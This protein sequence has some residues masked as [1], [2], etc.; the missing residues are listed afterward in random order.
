MRRVRSAG[1]ASAILAASLAAGGPCWAQ[2]TTPGTEDA[3]RLAIEGMDKI[4]KALDL[5]IQAVPQYAAPEVLENGDI[6]IR[7][8]HP[9]EAPKRKPKDDSE[10]DGTS[11]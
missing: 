9:E 6:I 4:L 2:S 1:L 5:L 7:R 11:T 3:Q 10:D 8:L